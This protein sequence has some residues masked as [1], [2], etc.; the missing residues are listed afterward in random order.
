MIRVIWPNIFGD[1]ETWAQGGAP[2]FA[3]LVYNSNNLGLW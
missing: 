2:E 1:P 3:N